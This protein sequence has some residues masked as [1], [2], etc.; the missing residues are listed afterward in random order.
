MNYTKHYRFIRTALWLFACLVPLHA[1]AAPPSIPG[2]QRSPLTVPE[3]RVVGVTA[4]TTKGKV[5]TTDQFGNPL[6]GYAAMDRL[7]QDEVDPNARAA[8]VREWQAPRTFDLI[9]P[10]GSSSAWLTPGPIRLIFRPDTAN[11][12]MDW[13][14]YTAGARPAGPVSGGWPAQAVG[15]ASCASY[16]LSDSP[17]RGFAGDAAGRVAARTCSESAITIACSALVSVPVRQ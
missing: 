1:I 16:T 7:C 9:F 17:L 10:V 8:T 11:D 15:K 4:T 12:Q 14:V 2:A 3:Y 6:I 13:E 5:Q